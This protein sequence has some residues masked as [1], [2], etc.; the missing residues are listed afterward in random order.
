MELVHCHIAKEAPKLPH[1]YPLLLKERGQIYH[2]KPSVGNERG[3]EIPQVISD[4]V[5]KLMAK[6]A[7]D[8]YQSGLELK[9]DLETC[10]SQIKETRTVSRFQVAQRDICERFIIPD[11]L[12]GRDKQVKQLLETCDRG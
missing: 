9:H 3:E 6:N 1:P 7:D 4:I 10:L 2:S 5:M 12:Y 8:R 11:K